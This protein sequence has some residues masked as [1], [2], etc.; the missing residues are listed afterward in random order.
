MLKLDEVLALEIDK[1]MLQLEDIPEEVKQLVEKRK[2][3]REEKNWSLSDEIR[4][5][6][7]KLGYTVKDTKDGMVVE[8]I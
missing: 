3:A 8:K 5:E 2:I 1:P 6:I 4:D 7:A